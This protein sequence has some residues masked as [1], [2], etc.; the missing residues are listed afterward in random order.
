MIRKLRNALLALASASGVLTVVLMGAGPILPTVP[1]SALQAST[2][3]LQSDHVQV[4]P[5]VH[6]GRPITVAAVT[7]QTT[8]AVP[9]RSG[10]RQQSVAMPYF[11]FGPALLIPRRAP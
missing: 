5:T 2:L 10:R 4:M 7:A 9:T 1:G 3:A 6:A 8:A 11:S